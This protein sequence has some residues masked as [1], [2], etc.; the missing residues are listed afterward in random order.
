MSVGFVMLAHTALDRAALVARHL[1][2]HGSPVVIHVDKRTPR[3]EYERLKK[4]IAD[5]DLIDLA[6]RIVCDWGTW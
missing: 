6:P 5:V 2:S 1:A 4:R 3:R